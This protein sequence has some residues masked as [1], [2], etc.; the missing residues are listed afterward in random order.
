MV[1][2]SDR[3][4]VSSGAV[5]EGKRPKLSYQRELTSAVAAEV[6][7]SSVDEAA[8]DVARQ[9]ARKTNAVENDPKRLMKESMR[10]CSSPS[11]RFHDKQHIESERKCHEPT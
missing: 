2:L 3:S 8:V 11:C 1:L 10:M 4:I 6:V 7:G 5:V 9:R